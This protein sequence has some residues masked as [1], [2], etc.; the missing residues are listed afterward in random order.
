M[1]TFTCP[2]LFARSKTI[3]DPG[4]TIDPVPVFIQGADKHN[5]GGNKHGSRHNHCQY[6]ARIASHLDK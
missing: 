3:A 6:Q 1:K 4:V 2:P 5:A